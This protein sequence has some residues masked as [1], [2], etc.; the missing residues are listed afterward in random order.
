MNTRTLAK[1][2]ERMPSFFE[3]FFNKPLL[4]LFD[5]GFPSRTMNVPAVNIT[6]R[7]DDYLVSMAAPGLKKEDFKIDVE[8]N[9]LTIS[10]EKEEEKEEKEEKYT[11]QEYSYSSFERSFTLPDEVNKD[12]IDA[13]YQDGVLKLVLPKK[14]EAK[15]MAISKQIAVK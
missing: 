2:T 3:D 1:R 8:G 4:D 10:S 14:E 11:R 15:K 13:H 5:G 12:K 9:M 7:K 6:D